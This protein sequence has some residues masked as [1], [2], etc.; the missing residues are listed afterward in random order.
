MIRSV[1]H[2]ASPTHLPRYGNAPS[3]SLGAEVPQSIEV[4][5][6]LPLTELPQQHRLAV[7][8]LI[9]KGAWASSKART[10]GQ[11]ERK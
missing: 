6:N 1:A 8:N 4:G 10:A 7:T 11:H 2:L 3:I 9:D 5:I